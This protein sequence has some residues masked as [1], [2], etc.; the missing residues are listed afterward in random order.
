MIPDFRNEP[1]TD[2]TDQ[3]NF[4]LMQKA[5]SQAKKEFNRE[6]ELI[7]DGKKIRTDDKFAS[8]NPSNPGQVVGYAFNADNDLVE[9]AV[10]SSLK[11]FEEWRNVSPTIRARYLF[12]TAALMRKRKAELTA[13]MILE[14]GKNWAEADGDVAEAIDFLDFY[15][16]RALQMAERQPLSRVKGEDNDLCYIPLGVGVIISPWNFPLAILTGMTCGPLVMGNSVIVK[17]ASNTPVIAYKL[18][19]LMEEAGVPKGVINLVYGGGSTVGT[20]LVRH[21]K[22]R[23]INFTGSKEVGL[24]IME[25][26]GKVQKGQKWIKRAS[27][28][29]GGKNAIVVD[30]EADLDSAVACI[31]ASAFGFQGQKCSACSRAIIDQKVYDY[32]EG[33][34]VEK[35]KSIKVG[36]AEKYENKMGPLID[37]D[38]LDKVLKYIDIG[39]QEGKLLCGGSRLQTEGYYVEPTIFSEIQSKD[40]LGQ[41]EIFGPVLSLIK[42][43]DFDEALHIANDTDYGLTGSVYSNSWAKL[44]KARREFHVGNLYFNRKSTAALVGAHPFGGFNMSG[45]GAKAG[46]RDYLLLFSQ[47]KSVSEE[48]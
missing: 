4:D 16:T 19:E 38:A 21:P 46:G 22:I 42:A 6:Y 20:H 30:S 48:L 37:Q 18:F 24:F 43:K 47:A 9:Q 23:F 32:V 5:I 15:G 29:M 10:N 25:E 35:A 31:A 41:E 26:A 14:S 27:V 1:A 7:I 45:T 3:N 44:E 36:P 17:P 34:L 40:R 13:V 28:E 39:K 8:L 33:R 2:F 11:A 12:K